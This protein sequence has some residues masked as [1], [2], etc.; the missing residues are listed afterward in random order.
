MLTSEKNM[1]FITQYKPLYKTYSYL[2]W[3]ERET[4]KF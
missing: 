3:L 4:K 1:N 2:R